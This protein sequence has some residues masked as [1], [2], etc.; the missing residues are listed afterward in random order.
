MFTLTTVTDT[1]GDVIT[2][3]H[4]FNTY[5]DLQLFKLQ[6]LDTADTTWI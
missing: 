1:R 4:E 5:A 2:E 3:H 6:V